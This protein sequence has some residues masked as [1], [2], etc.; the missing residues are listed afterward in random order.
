VLGVRLLG[1]L[2]DHAR[3]VEHLGVAVED[4]EL[5]LGL[6]TL[7]IGRRAAVQLRCQRFHFGQHR[8]GRQLSAGLAA[9]SSLPFPTPLPDTRRGKF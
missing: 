5:P 1:R 8:A 2:E 3:L 7:R 4:A 9:P 6:C